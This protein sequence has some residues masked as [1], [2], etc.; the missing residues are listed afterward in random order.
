V[1]KRYYRRWCF[2]RGVS[3]GMLDRRRPAPVRYLLGVPRFMVG[4]AV[5]NTIDTLPA[6]FGPRDPARIFK[7]ELAWWDLAGFVY[8]KHGARIDPYVTAIA[9]R[10]SRRANAT[11]RSGGGRSSPLPSDQAA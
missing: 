5:R 3:L 2:W 10:F 1:T 11:D 4:I 7:N 6:L 8:G 9:R